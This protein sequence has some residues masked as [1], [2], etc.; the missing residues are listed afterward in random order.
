LSGGSLRV[1][2]QIIWK[3]DPRGESVQVKLWVVPG[4]LQLLMPKL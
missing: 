2:D 4:A 3:A 1:D